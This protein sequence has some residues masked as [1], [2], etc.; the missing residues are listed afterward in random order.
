MD[1]AELNEKLNK[2]CDLAEPV[3]DYVEKHFVQFGN[4]QNVKN[5]FINRNYTR[6]HAVAYMLLER[7][8]DLNG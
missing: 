6:I 8:S 4:A 2:L 7:Q 3:I 1:R 5:G